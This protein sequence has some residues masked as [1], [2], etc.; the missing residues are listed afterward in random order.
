MSFKKGTLRVSLLQTP[1]REQQAALCSKHWEDMG[2]SLFKGLFL[3][4]CLRHQYDLEALSLIM[5]L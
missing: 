4:T 2:V 1:E 5:S 3:E